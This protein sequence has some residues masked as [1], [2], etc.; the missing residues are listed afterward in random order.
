MVIMEL[1]GCSLIIKMKKISYIIIAILLIGVIS[2]VTISNI[3]PNIDKDDIKKLK[4]CVGSAVYKITNET[5]NNGRCY[6]KIEFDNGKQFVFSV[7]E[8]GNYEENIKKAQENYFKYIIEHCSPAEDNKHNLPP[9][10]M[11]LEK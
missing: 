2:A 5:C 8:A 10:W 9:D 6:V 7:I 4:D 11:N 1:T 3:K